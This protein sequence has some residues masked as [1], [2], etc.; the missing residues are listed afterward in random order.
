M[1]DAE[2]EARRQQ[3]QT[4]MEQMQN[5][6]QS[7]RDKAVKQISAILTPKQ[8]ENFNKMLGKPFDLTLLNDGRGPDNPYN[9]ARGRGRGP[10]GGGPPGG[11]P[12]GGGGTSTANAAGAGTT[13]ASTTGTT[14]TAATSTKGTL[15]KPASKTATK[16]APTSKTTTTKTATSK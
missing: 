12:G 14:G 10:G 8:K 7:V 13:P 3:F 5:D 15:A 9:P 6:S 11:G 1:T 4:A 16:G 2:R